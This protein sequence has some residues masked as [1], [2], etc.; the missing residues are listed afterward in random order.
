MELPCWKIKSLPA[1]LCTTELCDK[2]PS[3]MN[4]IWARCYPRVDKP[5][6]FCGQTTWSY[7]ENGALAAVGWEWVELRHGVAV[8]ADPMSLQSNVDFTSPLDEVCDDGEKIILLNT[9]VCYLPWQRH[10]R[11]MLDTAR[12]KQ[13]A[14]SPMHIPPGRGGFAGFAMAA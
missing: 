10:V 7:E 12:T 9:L 14:M 13:A 11:S 8:L 5:D 1:V 4:P 2:A 3:V 6:L